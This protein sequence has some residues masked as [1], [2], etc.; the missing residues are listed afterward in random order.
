MTPS[1]IV[2]EVV[3][4]GGDGGRSGLMTDSGWALR[5]DHGQPCIRASRLQGA[6]HRLLGQPRDV[7]TRRSGIVSQIVGEVHVDARHAHIIHTAEL[8]RRRQAGGPQ[9]PAGKTGQVG[10]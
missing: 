10:R 5:A 7:Q 2:V 3:L 6:T 1:L 9:L 8:W 4:G